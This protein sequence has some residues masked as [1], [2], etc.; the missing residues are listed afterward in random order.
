MVLVLVIIFVSSYSFSSNAIQSNDTTI[1]VWSGNGAFHIEIEG[2]KANATRWGYTVASSTEE[3][4]ASLLEGVDILIVNAPDFMLDIEIAAAVTWFNEARGR[5]IWVTGES[6]YGGYWYPHGGITNKGVNH[7]LMDIGAHIFIQD[8][9][10]NDAEMNDGAG[11]RP[12]PNVPN[13]VDEEAKLIMDSEYGKVQTTYMH[14]PTAVIPYSSVSFDGLGTVTSFSALDKCVWLVNTSSTGS[15]ADQDFDDDPYWEGY[16]LWVN[17]SLT[18]AA[19]EWDIGENMGKVV[20]TGE[21]I[22]ADYKYMFGYK[23][24]YRLDTPLQNIALTHALLDWLSGKLTLPDSTD[25]STTDYPVITSVYLIYSLSG[26]VC[27]TI[28]FRKR[29]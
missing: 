29:R 13:T 11:Y 20:C 8:D 15:I 25:T 12:L 27:L 16:P 14:G 23:A 17:M 19:A 4:N 24:L 1:L 2:F 28:A 10:V 26:I 7:L 3:L 6:D 9:A 18:M 5:S 22:F 21:S